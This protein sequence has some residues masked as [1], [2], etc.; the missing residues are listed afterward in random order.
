MAT[1]SGVSARRVSPFLGI[2]FSLKSHSKRMLEDSHSSV[3]RALQIL[4]GRAE[5][6]SLSFSIT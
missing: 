2:E 4:C 5:S 1:R 3:H 6:Q